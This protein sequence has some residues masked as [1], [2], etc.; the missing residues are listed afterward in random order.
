MVLREIVHPIFLQCV[1][2]TTDPFWIMVFN[3]LSYNSCF[4]GTYLSKGTYCCSIKSKEFIYKYEGKK[5]EIIFNEITAY[6]KGI[7]ITS[8]SD[9]LVFIKEYEDAKQCINDVLQQDWSDIRKKNLKDMLFQNYMIR[10]KN[11]YE[12]KDIQIKKL[13]SFINFCLLLKTMTNQSVT[14]INGRIESINGITFS[15]GKYKID[16]E[17][18]ALEDSI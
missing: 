10:M 4:T 11:E 1:Q 7:N 3:E 13:Y 9:A 18:Y 8:K 2:F 16:L 14:Y 6:L 17:L 15:K 12:L 5:P